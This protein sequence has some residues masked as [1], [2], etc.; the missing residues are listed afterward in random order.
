MADETEV[1]VQTSNPIAPSVNPSYIVEVVPGHLRMHTVS[2]DK[3]DMLVSGNAPL[4]LGFFGL[5][6][7]AC[8]SFGIVL[9]TVATLS[10]FDKSLFA[11]L[12]YSSLIMG[13]FF[14]IRC[15]IAYYETRAKVNAIKGL[16]KPN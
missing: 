5:C 2:E 7:G 3:L 16:K 8:I 13:L 9:R 15:T 6:L 12:F 1:K 11:M 14:G 4:H 10:D